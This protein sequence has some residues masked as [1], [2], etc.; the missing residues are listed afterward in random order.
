MVVTEIKKVGKGQRYYL[1]VYDKYFACIEA[2]ILAKT[3]IKTGQEVNNEELEKLKIDNGDYACFNRSLSILAKSM[4][5]EKMLRDYLI[6]KSY[7]LECIDRAI[8]KLKDYGY[9]DDESF[10]ENYIMFYNQS[11]SKRKLKFELK[12]K[13]INDEIINSKLENLNEEEELEKCRK[14]AKKYL[15]N[16]PKD[17]KTKQK[18]FNHMVSKGYDYSDI[19]KTWE[20]NLNDWD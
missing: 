9:I 16:K 12:N 1:F 8:V 15:T 18:F 17:L 11:K 5:S 4:K 14:I 3:Q 2:E 10:C 20:E 13:G 6:K 7:P 19:L